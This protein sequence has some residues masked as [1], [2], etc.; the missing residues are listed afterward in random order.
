VSDA[1]RTAYLDAW[2]ARIEA[3]LATPVQRQGNA[4]PAELL[5]S[6]GAGAWSRK[7]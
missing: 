5:A 7:V 3:A 6:V 4:D 1:E 2:Q